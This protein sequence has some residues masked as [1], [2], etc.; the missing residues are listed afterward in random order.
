MDQDFITAGIDIGS[1]TAQAVLVRNSSLLAYSN[2]PVGI[3]RLT[4]ACQALSMAQ[5]SAGITDEPIKYIVG[6][7]Y[8]RYQIPFA[9][10]NMTEIT[11][12]AR[13]AHY[14]FPDAATVLDIGGQD[15]KIIAC[16]QRGQ[17]TAFFM[18]ERCAAGTG[19][20]IDVISRILQVPLKMIGPLSLKITE[21]PPV[22]SSGCV[23]FAKSE[24]LKLVRRGYSREAVLAA[25]CQ[26]MVSRLL[27]LVQKVE[28]KNRF[29]LTGGVALNP[30][31]VKRLEKAIGVPIWICPEPQIAG[32]LGA[33]LIARQLYSTAIQNT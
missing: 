33:A 7:G 31:I 30:G 8:G 15:S 18:N 32:A 16:G 11:C 24:A 13:G 20:S 23:V 1:S 21:E 14:F 26:A 6:T 9:N 29:V 4:T 28:I 5:K 12:H 22:V 27:S 10:K 17:V 3:D 19:R 25:Y 2:L